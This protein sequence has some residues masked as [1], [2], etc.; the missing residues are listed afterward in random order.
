MQV[1][2]YMEGPLALNCIFCLGEIG[3][4]LIKSNIDKNFGKTIEK[5]RRTMCFFNTRGF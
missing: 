5:S 4:C 1:P 2:G 3:P